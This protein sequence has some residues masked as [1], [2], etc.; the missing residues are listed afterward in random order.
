MVPS[1]KI[2]DKG[3]QRAVIEESYRTLASERTESVN[4]EVASDSKPFTSG[5]QNGF[6][7]LFMH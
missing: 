7:E 3:N 6:R 2:G 5:T 4:K 1:F